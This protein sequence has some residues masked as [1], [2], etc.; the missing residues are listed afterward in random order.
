MCPRGEI[1]RHKGLKILALLGVPVRVWPRAPNNFYSINNYLMRI[2]YFAFK[3]RHRFKDLNNFL[4][5]K[6]YGKY[7][8]LNLGG[9]FKSF[10]AKIL[11]KFKIGRAISCDGRPLILNKSEGINFFIRGT[12]SNIPRDLRI[13]NN[14]YVSIKNHSKNNSE[15]IFQ[16]YPIKIRKSIINKNLKII[17]M[18][19]VNLETTTEERLI[20]DR[21]K[22]VILNDFTTIDKKEFWDEATN[23]KNIDKTMNL[24]RKIKHLLR[25][26]IVSFLK[27][28]FNEKVILIGDKW[29][30]YSINSL[31]S[32]YKI[33]KNN[34]TYR[35]NICLDLGCIEGSSSLYSRSN[36]IIESG[37]LIIQ[38]Q[39]ID[40]NQMWKNLSNKILFKDFSE[41]II[42]IKK[43]LNDHEYS[44]RLLMEINDNFHNSEKMTEHNLDNVFK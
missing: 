1:G 13:L 39:Q 5:T 29:K 30:D 31:P 40:H 14:N 12:N 11:T 2:L 19:G 26:E 21:Y 23:E 36:Q 33:K 4:R 15:N 44:N 24:Y 18:S 27:K 20:W 37:G 8:I 35:G 32:V 41:L 25:F 10:L 16:V 9:P 17:Y 22:D 42:L 28:E 3:H 7:L 43:L 34:N 38:S 6:K